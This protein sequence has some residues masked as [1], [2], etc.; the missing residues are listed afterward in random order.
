MVIWQRNGNEFYKSGIEISEYYDTEYYDQSYPVTQT[1]I[2]KKW[3]S[4]RYNFCN[5]TDW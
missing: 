5:S 3:E 4:Q 2:E 1:Y